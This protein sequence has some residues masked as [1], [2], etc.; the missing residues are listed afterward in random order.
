MGL[1]DL[2]AILPRLTRVQATVVVTAMSTLLVFLGKFVWE[3]EA[4]VTTF[5]V[6]LTS[7]A[8]PWAVVTLLGFWRSG[9]GF[10][11]PEPAGLQPATDRRP[12]L[13]PPRMEPR[14]ARCLAGGQRGGRLSNSTDTY[15]GPI[16]EAFGG[17]DS[18]FITSGVA[19]AI[20]YLTTIALHPRGWPRPRWP[21]SSPK[22]EDPDS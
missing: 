20:V 6:V 1:K 11:K 4:A 18:S 13:V 19:A 14:R 3:A 10:D 16:A 22:Q 2:D 7:L 9:G 21:R 15:T 5:V 17:V 12:V 8:T